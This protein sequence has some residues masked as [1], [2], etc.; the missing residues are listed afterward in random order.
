MIKVF[1]AGHGFMHDKD[2]VTLDVDVTTYVKDDKMY[3]GPMT[4][5]LL[6]TGKYEPNAKQKEYSEVKAWK[7]KAKLKEHF[8]CSDGTSA[9][10]INKAK[11]WDN[12]KKAPTDIKV[13]KLFKFSD[14]VQ[15]FM[16][17]YNQ[18]IRLSDLVKKLNASLGGADKYELHWTA[19]RSKITG[20][21]DKDLLSKDTGMN[22]GDLV[23]VKGFV[24]L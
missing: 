19:C 24:K 23:E 15:V 4:K 11:G 3:D 7:K 17:V 16:S 13:G 9:G 6:D 21:A 14:D 2:E 10:D 12:A 5:P 18:A 20:K 8:F 1:L 22:Q